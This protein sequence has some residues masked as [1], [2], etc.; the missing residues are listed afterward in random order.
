M[1][2]PGSLFRYIHCLSAF[3]HRTHHTRESLL[4][5]LLE[6]APFGTPR[7]EYRS[8]VPSR[9]L[10]DIDALPVR[11]GL[12]PP[13]RISRPPSITVSD[14]SPLLDRE[15]PSKANAYNTRFERMTSPYSRRSPSKPGIEPAPRLRS[16]PIYTAWGHH[17]HSPSRTL[18]QLHVYI[19]SIYTQ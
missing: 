13:C 11:L 16:E 14:T 19:V 7:L 5:L 17:S 12:R 1:V 10:F 18:C 8:G 4:A 9:N 2:T 6:Q 3:R 15:C